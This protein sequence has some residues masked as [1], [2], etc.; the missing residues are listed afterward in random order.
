MTPTAVSE[1]VEQLTRVITMLVLP[2]SL[3]RTVWRS[4]QAVPAWVPV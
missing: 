4:L 3:C 2:T 1:I